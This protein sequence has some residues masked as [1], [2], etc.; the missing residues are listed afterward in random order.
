MD[1][2]FPASCL[3]SIYC[4]IPVAFRDILPVNL[5]EKIRK[6]ENI[7]THHAGFKPGPAAWETDAL[8]TGSYHTIEES[9][10]NALNIIRSLYMLR[11]SEFRQIRCNIPARKKVHWK[12]KVHG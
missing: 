6:T 9:F 4:K 7:K 8:S 11:T 12:C 2:N 10:K 3:L 1:G 5:P